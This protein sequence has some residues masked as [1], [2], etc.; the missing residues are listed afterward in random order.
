MCTELREIYAQ[1]CELI[2]RHIKCGKC[3]FTNSFLFITR[4]VVWEWRWI[5]FASF[6][7]TPS[8]F[9]NSAPRHS[10]AIAYLMKIAPQRHGT[11]TDNAER[12][13]FLTIIK[14]IPIQI[15]QL[16]KYDT[17]RREIMASHAAHCAQTRAGRY[18]MISPQHRW[19]YLVLKA[20][21]SSCSVK[22]SDSRS[23][24]FGSIS[25]LRPQRHQQHNWTVFTRSTNR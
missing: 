8:R 21:F 18:R 19:K 15:Q 16:M 11:V 4:G 14:T 3:L 13:Y 5:S 17:R 24:T 22:R 10:V 23:I 2:T 12:D 9:I 6:L 1:R 25:L 20:R 7:I